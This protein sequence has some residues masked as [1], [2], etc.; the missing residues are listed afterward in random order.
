LLNQGIFIFADSTYRD[1][2]Q[3]VE[4]LSETNEP[5]FVLFSS[6][7]RVPKEEANYGIKSLEDLVKIDSQQVLRTIDRNAPQRL[8]KEFAE[9]HRIWPYTLIRKAMQQQDVEDPKIGFY[10]NG[11]DNH[12]RA[13]T[14]M[15]ATAGAEM[16]VMRREGDFEGGVLDKTPYGRNLRVRVNSRTEKEVFYKF[17]LSRLPMH[18]RGDPRQFSDWIN[19]GHN[20]S[21]PDASY[22]G[23]EHEQ[24][25]NPVIVW[26]APSVFA[27]YEA[28][29]F[30]AERPWQKQFRINPFPFPI[31][32]KCV[33]YIDNLRLQSF[34]FHETENGVKLEVLNKHEM[35]RQ[36]GARTSLRGYSNCWRHWGKSDTS[37]LYQLRD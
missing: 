3:K 30:V 4:S 24:R 21:D 22:R 16:H 18:K 37:Y 25:T 35:D 10:W 20:S 12:A 19:I 23:S 8:T 33:D 31:D 9:K 11:L 6:K 7:F 13:V 32:K 2:V 29:T 14:W 36:I 1:A 26:S 28:M 5:R 17:T 15:K 27:F 34:I